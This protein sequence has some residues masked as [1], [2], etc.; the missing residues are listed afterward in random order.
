MSDLPEVLDEIRERLGLEPYNAD[1][2][3]AL[4]K[5][6]LKDRDF[7]AAR[8]AYERAIVLDPA[9]PWSYLYL[10]NLFYW[11]RDYNEAIVQFH[12]ASR[13]APDS[14]IVYVCMADAYHALGDLALADQF[15]EKSVAV[16]PDS[17]NAREN[18]VR[19]RK[20]KKSMTNQ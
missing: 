8:A 12:H 20:I 18:L 11:Q 9:D 13:L 19:W 10:G 17:Q 3:Q 6:L 16:E 14:A 4:G 1:L 7:E 2:Y 5:A 15:Y